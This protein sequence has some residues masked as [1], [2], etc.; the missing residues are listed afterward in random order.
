M[1]SNWIS[2]YSGSGIGLLI[3]VLMGIAVSPTVGI[4]IGTLSSTLAVL[5]GLNDKHF[6]NAKAMRIG[7]FGFACVLGVFLG[8]FMR[9]H[10]VLSP[11]IQEMKKE[12]TDVNY[13]EPQALD[14]IAFK[15]FG[16]LNK[17]WRM[18]A[19]SGDSTSGGGK[20]N[21]SNLTQIRHAGVLYAA[22]VNMDA[23]DELINTDEHLKTD[24]IITNF[25]LTGGF[26]KNLAISVEKNLD[27]PDQKIVLLAIKDEICSAESAKVTDGECG[28]LTNIDET[29]SLNDIKTEFKKLGGIWW[30]L[31]QK[32]DSLKINDAVK[33]KSLLLLKNCLCEAKK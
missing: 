13:K 30:A 24:Q 17:D 11:S 32:I 7:S 10:N 20:I 16:I 33:I 15:E 14:F 4:I 8:I 12:Y 29:S 31:A 22:N 19:S 27:E 23:C 1:N 9:T 3:G 25:K 28:K 26:W 2:F 18:A 6:S 21:T 5:L